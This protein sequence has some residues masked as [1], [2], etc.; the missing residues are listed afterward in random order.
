M[1]NKEPL[2]FLITDDDA[3]D[4]EFIQNALLKQEIKSTIKSFDNGKALLEYIE[5]DPISKNIILL[6]LNM[7]IMNGY[8]TLRNIKKNKNL[9]NNFIIILTSSVKKEDEQI[10]KALGCIAFFNKPLSMLEFDV[11]GKDIVV[12]ANNF[13]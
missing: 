8:E 9:K 10:C 4:R 3:D 12:L 6:D 2:N 11:L 5:K 1:S 7:P 13:S